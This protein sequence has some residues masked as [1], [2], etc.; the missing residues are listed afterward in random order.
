MLAKIQIA[1]RP[2]N[3]SVLRKLVIRYV[4]N[5]TKVRYHYTSIRMSLKQKEKKS[6]TIPSSGQD[7]VQVGLSD[8]VVRMRK[9]STTLDNIF[10]ASYEVKHPLLCVTAIPLVGMSCFSKRKFFQ[11]K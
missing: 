11:E 1:N 5:K 3:I 7:E 8:R 9:D 2:M 10:A 6:L 4:K